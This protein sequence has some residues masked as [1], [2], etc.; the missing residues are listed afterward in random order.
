[1]ESEVE[2]R[3]GRVKA[4][5]KAEQLFMVAHVAGAISGLCAALGASLVLLDEGR[6]ASSRV[7]NNVPLPNDGGPLSQN[8]K[9]AAKQYFE[10]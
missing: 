8:T 7:T 2:S 3:G 6:I 1:M 5:S 10:Y 4:L 9:S